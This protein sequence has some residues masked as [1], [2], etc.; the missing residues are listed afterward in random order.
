MRI[1]LFVLMLMGVTTPAI[2]AQSAA[3]PDKNDPQAK[4]ILDK[5]RKNTKP[6]KRSKRLSA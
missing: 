3:Q 1:F 6:I 4:K 5:V 2:I